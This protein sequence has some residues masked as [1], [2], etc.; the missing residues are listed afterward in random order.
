MRSVLLGNGINIQFGG[1]AYMS[2]YIMQR[3]KYRA[4]LDAYKKL[5]ADDMTANDIIKMLEA[6]VEK[7]NKLN[8]KGWM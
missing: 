7:A 8:P 1:K 6:F 5:F 2:S 3:I 4:R